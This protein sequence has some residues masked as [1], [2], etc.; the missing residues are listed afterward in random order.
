MS[1]G[2]STSRPREPLVEPWS[3]SSRLTLSLVQGRYSV[4]RDLGRHGLGD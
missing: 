4:H 2:S 1:F 3:A